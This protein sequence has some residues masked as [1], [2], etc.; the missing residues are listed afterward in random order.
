MK[1]PEVRDRIGTANIRY[2]L[3]DK[4]ALAAVRKVITEARPE[5]LG[6]E[7]WHR[8][9]SVLAQITSRSYYKVARAEHG[10]PMLYD[11]SRYTLL[12]T[13]N[14]TLAPEQHVG[15]LPGRK[16][17]LP[18]SIAT[19]AIFWDEVLL[20]EVSAIRFHL[21]AEVQRGKGYRETVA[22]LRRV[23][24]HKTERRR[25]RKVGIRQRRKGR[26]VYLEGDGNFDGLRLRGFVSCWEGR[27]PKGT[28]GNRAVD[29]I[30]ASTPARDVRTIETASDHRAVVAVY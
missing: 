13:R 28:L 30:F 10:P 4:A 5:I 27:K 21:T 8:P 1:P 12:R 17:T 6:L 18:A 9:S 15:F 7:E 19:L 2:T 25:L 29:I 16:T 26:R 3:S 23:L 14:V 11:A 22:H 20:I 24:R